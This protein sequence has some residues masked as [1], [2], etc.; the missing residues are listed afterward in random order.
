MPQE[1]PSREDPQARRNGETE[2]PG[3]PGHPVVDEVEVLEELLAQVVE[4]S[5][6]KAAPWFADLRGRGAIVTGAATGIGRAIALELARHGAHIAFNYLDDGEDGVREDADRTARELRELEVKVYCRPCDIR[7]STDVEAFVEEAQ[8]VIGRVDVLVN[9]AGIG[10]DRALWRMSDREW[11][12]VVET[13]LTG[14][15]HMIRALAPLFRDQQ[16]GKIVNISSIHGLRAE[17]GL[18]NYAA[19]KAGILGLTRAAAVEL[20]PSNVNVNAVAPGYI[21]TTRLTDAVP[22]EILD[23]ARE[24]SVLGRLG[25]PQDVA[26]VVLFLCSEQARHITGAVIPVDGGHLL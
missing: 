25:D 3:Q 22:A 12:D 8:E 21:R 5:R 17:F 20:G 19:S 13:N 6:P 11:N 26:N 14:T 16:N 7:E 24:R 10:R 1:E 9:N 2:P 18:A 4:E 15:F 23:R